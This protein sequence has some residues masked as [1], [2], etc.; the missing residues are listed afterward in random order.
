MAECRYCQDELLPDAA[1]CV[2][3][4]LPT[5]D[6]CPG[7]GADVA[8][9]TAECGACHVP[10]LH[11]HGCGR[12]YTVQHIRC[13]NV[14]WNCE[15]TLLAEPCP[16][17]GGLHA[18]THRTRS[19]SLAGTLAMERLGDAAWVF[20]DERYPILDVGIAYGRVYAWTPEWLLA[21]PTDLQPPGGSAPFTFSASDPR[22]R[23]SER[24]AAASR[25]Y[26]APEEMSVAWG[27][28]CVL[29]TRQGGKPQV[30]CFRADDVEN[31]V[32]LDLEDACSALPL[33]GG[34]LVWTRTDGIA[35][36]HWVQLGATAPDHTAEVPAV[37]QPAYAPAAVHLGS[38][39]AQ[40]IYRGDDESVIHLRPPELAPQVVLPADPPRRLGPVSTVG[41]H[42]F[43]L[44]GVGDAT[45]VH[46][47]DLGSRA[48]DASEFRA[49]CDL[50]LRGTGSR[51]FVHLPAE[52]AWTA[53]RFDAWPV[54]I[55]PLRMK[56]PANEDLLQDVVLEAEGQV[57]ILA[58]TRDAGRLD[59]RLLGPQG[60]RA[61][62]LLDGTEARLVVAGSWLL[63]WT[64]G[65][66]R[67][68]AW[69]LA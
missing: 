62:G 13:E 64:E 35:E 58:L 1:F 60:D 48:H 57:E 9:A 8:L 23:R 10:L 34:C 25:G 44:S 51:R 66:P 39:G 63:A 14:D 6:A 17:W 3:C 33:P 15:G 54:R 18:G 27:Q 7:C 29:A 20:E 19:A 45:E 43:V 16:S 41:N 21:F 46:R 67:L 38:E 37:P 2:R 50:I 56:R 31:G 5:T 59:L 52:R 12:T 11:C 22:V 42:A 61:L 49:E 55:E 69:R 65:T 28:V 40:V 32:V 30:H 24:L 4:G 53:V 68:Q 47:F 26:G 36:A